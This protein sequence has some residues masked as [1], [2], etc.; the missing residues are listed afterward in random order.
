LKAKK[1]YGQHFLRDPEIA[2]RISSYLGY[3]EQVLEIGP[4]KGIMTKSLVEVSK[5]LKAVEIDEEAIEYLLENQVLAEGRIINAD[6]LNLQLSK[7]FEG[8]FS[9]IGNFPYYISSQIVFKII[10]N[11][12]LI[13]EMVGMFQKEVADRI[14]SQSGSKVYGGISVLTASRYNAEY[15]FTLQENDFSPPPKVKSAV[16]RFIRK[17]DPMTDEDYAML[18]KVVKAGFN[19]RRKTLRNS[20]KAILGDRIPE[21]L[22]SKRPEHCDLE[23]FVELASLLK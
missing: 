4:G 6:F 15:L 13:P 12:E 7:V 3:R 1:H 14:C 21:H 16:I 22:S 11:Y 8:Q 23:D 20:L 19:Q 10:E 18:A 9:V 5:V 17:E 2:R